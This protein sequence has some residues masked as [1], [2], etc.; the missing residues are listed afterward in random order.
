[1]YTNIAV[2]DD[3]P[4]DIIRT[5]DMIFNMQGNWHVDQYTEG[6]KLIDEVKSGKSYDLL[7]LDIYLKSESGIEVAK[8]LRKTIPKTPIVFITVSRE[9][10]VEA[11]SMEALHYIVKPVRQEDIVEVFRRLS[12]KPEP[13]HIL[14]IQ[15]DRTLAV[16]FQDEI[17]RVESHG[18]S[19]AISCINDTAYSVWKPYREIDGLLDDTFIRVKKGVTL[20]MR[21]IARMTT[22]DCTTRDG[23]TY[24]LRRDRAKE[25]RER[26]FTFLESELKK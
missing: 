5:E 18:H 10:A 3:N 24:L 7:I 19:T 21:F 1:M 2:L 26:Y 9:H 25:I 4:D 14:A 13:R 8:E 12:R 22:R 20:N 17:I 15:F 6:Q 23:K 11:Y 16:L